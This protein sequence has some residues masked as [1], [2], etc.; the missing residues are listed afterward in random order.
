MKMVGVVE[1]VGEAVTK[2]KSG[3]RVAVNVETF[4]GECFF[5][6]MDGSTIALTR[7]AV[8]RLVAAS[9]ADRRS[10]YECRLPIMV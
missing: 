10:L 2:V 1:S 5:V 3:D 8:G 6:G 4:C 7:M 9:M